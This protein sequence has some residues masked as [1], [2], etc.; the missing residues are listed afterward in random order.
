MM[1]SVRGRWIAALGLLTAG[2]AFAGHIATTP[3]VVKSANPGQLRLLAEA[4]RSEEP[5][6]K[7]PLTAVSVPIPARSTHASP[8][9]R[10]SR[11]A[12]RV[13]PSRPAPVAQERA[14]GETPVSEASPTAADAVKN[15]ALMGVTHSEGEDHAWLVDLSTR[16]REVVDEGKEAWGFTVKRIEDEHIVLARGGDQFTLRLGEKEIPVTEAPVETVSQTAG[17]GR[18]GWGGRNGGWGGNRGG[19][20]GDRRAQFR[21]WM[22][23]NGGGGGFRGNRSWGGNRSQGGGRGSWSGGGASS[24]NNRNRNQGGGRSWGG[25]GFNPA[26][27]AFGGG[28]WGNRNGSRSGGAGPTSNPQTA[29]RRGGQLIGGADPIQTPRPI[30]NPQT[31]RRLG[32]NS[33]GQ[34]FGSGNYRNQN[35]RSG[36]NRSGGR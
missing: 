2:S 17:E 6:T 22:A 29:R 5:T 12:V 24:N 33:G 9:E 10:T 14:G 19:G 16:D 20:G 23:A 25:G 30:S 27:M 32:T 28:F 31:T 18:G 13:A 26:A 7:L 21:Q 35:S 34:A 3:P 8:D 4:V 36:N 1:L 15:I 11:A